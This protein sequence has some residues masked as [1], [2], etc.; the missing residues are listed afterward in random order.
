ML[1]ISKN[2]QLQPRFSTLSRLQ[3]VS[4]V[5][6]ACSAGS[7]K[8]ISNFLYISNNYFDKNTTFEKKPDLTEPICCCL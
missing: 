1:K 5:V 3:M 7:K 4:G 2:G 6:S 8:V